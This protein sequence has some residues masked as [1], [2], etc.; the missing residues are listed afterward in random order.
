MSL[1]SERERVPRRKSPTWSDLHPRLR[2]R[3]RRYFLEEAILRRDRPDKAKRFDSERST[4]ILD[5]T[6]LFG[7]GDRNLVDNLYQEWWTTE[8]VP[9]DQKLRREALHIEI[10]N[11]RR[12]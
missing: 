8:M 2:G 1:Q 6:F 12:S 11:L 4:Y 3:L 10:E 7:Y 9:Y 5:M